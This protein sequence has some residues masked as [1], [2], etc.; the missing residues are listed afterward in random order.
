[1]DIGINTGAIDAHLAA[2][3]N[4]LLIV[5]GPK[6]SLFMACQV[7]LGIALMFALTTAPA[8]RSAVAFIC[9]RKSKA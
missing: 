3:L 5:A 9:R 1:V 2:L 6:I 8:T 4:L 7:E